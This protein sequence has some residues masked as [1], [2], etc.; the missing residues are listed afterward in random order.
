MTVTALITLLRTPLALALM[1]GLAS[2]AWGI[3]QGYGWGHAKGLDAGFDRGHLAGKK[4]GIAETQAA[5]AAANNRIRE[6]TDAAI[7]RGDAETPTPDDLNDRRR[8]CERDP[9]CVRASDGGP[10]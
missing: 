6:L 3:H 1:L 7:A 4:A 2:Y 9:N 8:L 10:G 5:V